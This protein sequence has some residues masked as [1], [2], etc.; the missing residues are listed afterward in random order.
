MQFLKDDSAKVI[1][2]LYAPT[3]DI[4]SV[5]ELAKQYCMKQTFYDTPRIEIHIIQK[6]AQ[7]AEVNKVRRYFDNHHVSLLKSK[8]GIPFYVQRC[9][10]FET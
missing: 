8:D 7:F 5:L 3:N 4:A 1:G 9:N 2:A 10:P 6:F